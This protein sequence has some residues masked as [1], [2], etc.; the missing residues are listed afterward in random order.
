MMHP[1]P[2]RC[3]N[4]RY[5]GKRERFQHEQRKDQNQNHVSSLLPIQ[6]HEREIL[7]LLERHQVVI[8]IGQ[9]GCGKTTQ[10]CQY[11][12]KAIWTIPGE[13]MVC[14]TQPRR[15]SAQTVAMR[16]CEEIFASSSS[17][18]SQ[19]C[20]LGGTVG[21]SVRFETM[22]SSETEILFCTDG[23]LLRE[24]LED[25]LLQKYSAVM[26][27]EAHERSLNT[28]VLLGLLKKVTR[29]RKKIQKTKASRASRNVPLRRKLRTRKR[30][31]R[32]L[33]RRLSA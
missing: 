28:D 17:S 5:D 21:V 18:S 25:P 30:P 3:S 22:K 27:D 33:W 16:V 29:K 31:P 20:C 8:I 24:L 12:R 2:S 26:V 6:K 32:R 11:L 4:S 15:A 10:I 19:R 14:V 9:T 7:Y 23:S 13:K 1:P